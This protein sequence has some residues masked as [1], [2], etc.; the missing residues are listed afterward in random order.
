LCAAYDSQTLVLFN[1]SDLLSPA[2]R[3]TLL[4]QLPATAPP[5][6]IAS[7]QTQEGWDAFVAAVGDNVGKLCGFDGSQETPAI[8]HARHRAHIQQTLA[9]IDA[10]LVG[11]V[12][13]FVFVERLAM[14]VFILFYGLCNSG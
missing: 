7:C 8:A 2:Q 3:E 9:A 12:G 1:K 4:A 5:V 6:V 13:E 10:A 11:W 14:K